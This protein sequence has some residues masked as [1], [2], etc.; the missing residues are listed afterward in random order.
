[1]RLL[2]AHGAL[3]SERGGEGGGRVLRRIG[4]MVVAV[5]NCRGC[6]PAS[7]FRSAGAEDLFISA[8]GEFLAGPLGTPRAL[9]KLKGGG[10]GG[11]A[12]RRYTDSTVL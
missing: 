5:R 7:P 1:M 2:D 4:N 6:F 9:G 11:R 10:G 8:C 3:S 12:S